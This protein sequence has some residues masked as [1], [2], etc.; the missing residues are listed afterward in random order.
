MPVIPHFSNECW[1]KFEKDFYWPSYEASLLEEKDCIIV[2]QVNGKKRGIF[3]IAVNSDEDLIIKN[4]KNID[5]VSRNIKDKMIKK[6]Y[7]R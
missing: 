2:V 1:L 5:N 3:K 4:A 6:K 7:L